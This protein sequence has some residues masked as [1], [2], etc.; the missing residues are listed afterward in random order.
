MTKKELKERVSTLGYS[1]DSAY[2]LFSRERHARSL[3]GIGE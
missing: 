2:Q 1:R 3:P